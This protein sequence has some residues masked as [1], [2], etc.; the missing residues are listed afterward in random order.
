ML[1]LGDDIESSR[2][3]AGQLHSWSDQDAALPHLGGLTLP[4]S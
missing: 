1:E 2:F 4:L 3:W